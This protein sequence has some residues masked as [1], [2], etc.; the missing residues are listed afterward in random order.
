MCGFQY[1]WMVMW[2]QILVVNW[3]NYFVYISSN[4]VDLY[5]HQIL[6]GHKEQQTSVIF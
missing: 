6:L 3:Q 5:S 4:R 2:S 1:I